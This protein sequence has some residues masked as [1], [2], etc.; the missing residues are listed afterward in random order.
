MEEK[1]FDA[2]MTAMYVVPQIKYIARN[3]SKIKLNV[4]SVILYAS[5]TTVDMNYAPREYRAINLLALDYN[6][7]KLDFGWALLFP[8]FVRPKSRFYYFNNFFEGCG[9]RN[10]MC[11]AQF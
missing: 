3:A 2:K 1:L 5:I 10:K 6:Q 9:F 4:Y 11:C 7:P 8:Y